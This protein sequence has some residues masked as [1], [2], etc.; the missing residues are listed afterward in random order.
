MMGGDPTPTVLVDIGSRSTNI[1]FLE[2]GSLVWSAQTD[3]AGS[4]LTQALASSLGINPLRAEELKRERGVLGTGPSYE[5]STIMIPFLDAIINEVKKSQF[6]YAS[7]F[8]SAKKAERIILAGGG[9]NL[10]GIEKYFEQAFGLPTGKISPFLK[11]EYPPEISPLVP[12]LNPLMGVA[13]G[14]GMKEFI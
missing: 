14:L 8:P 12:E 9:A 2:G 11:F 13:L 7:Q 5:L 10:L 6:A 1:I 4:S 3:F